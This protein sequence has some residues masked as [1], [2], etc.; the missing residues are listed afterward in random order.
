M[1]IKSAT[2]YS[3]YLPPSLLFR[4]PAGPLSLPK[5]A[6]DA[7]GAAGDVQVAQNGP[8]KIYFEKLI[9]LFCGKLNVCS[10]QPLPM[11]ESADEICVHVVS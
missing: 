6:A 8:L 10:P 1:G 2:H 3:P 7:G 11:P 5:A 4:S 9:N